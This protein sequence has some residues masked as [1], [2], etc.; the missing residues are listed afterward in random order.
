MAPLNADFSQ[1]GNTWGV[2]KPPSWRPTRSVCGDMLDRQFQ[3]LQKE[4]GPHKHGAH[5]KKL[6]R[7]CREVYIKGRIAEVDQIE[8]QKRL[9]AHCEK[10]PVKRRTVADACRPANGHPAHWRACDSVA[11]CFVRHV[12]PIEA[13]D[14]D[15]RFQEHCEKTGRHQAKPRP[16]S[17][18]VTR[19][20]RLNCPYYPERGKD[21]GRSGHTVES[22]LE[23]GWSGDSHPSSQFISASERQRPASAFSSVG[24]SGERHEVHERGWKPP[25]MPFGMSNVASVP[26]LPTQAQAVTED[27]R[28]APQSGKGT[29]A[30]GAPGKGLVL[31]LRLHGAQRRQTFRGRRNTKAMDPCP[32]PP[33]IAGL[34]SN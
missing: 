30:G 21:R 16:Q 25:S 20:F 11:R 4:I 7:F 31:E 12:P 33:Q 22:L 10:G 27:R 26:A 3:L 19:A 5:A 17:A 32:A 13:T 9:N 34:E 14:S 6:G 18:P 23:A 15:V 24:R 8:A 28:E 29:P 2:K 1:D